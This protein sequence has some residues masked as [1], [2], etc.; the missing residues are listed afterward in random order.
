[1]TLI[2]AVV[3]IIF[4]LFFVGLYLSVVYIVYNL[5]TGK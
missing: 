1:M 5:I 3:G 2:S 4:T